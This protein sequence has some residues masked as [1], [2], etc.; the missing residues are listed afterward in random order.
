MTTSQPHDE[1]TLLQDWA[2]FQ[3]SLDRPRCAKIS[4]QLNVDSVRD[5]VLHVVI[6]IGVQ[7]V[8]F[9]LQSVIILASTVCP[10]KELLDQNVL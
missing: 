7:V 9:F 8:V 1:T 5:V 10:S 2:L 6:M 3:D 4:V